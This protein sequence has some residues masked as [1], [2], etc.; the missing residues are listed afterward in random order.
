MRINFLLLVTVTIFASQPAA[1]TKDLLTDEARW[2]WAL[3]LDK[4]SDFRNYIRLHPNGKFVQEAR[5]KLLSK[6]IE[7]KAR[8]LTDTPQC[9]SVLNERAQKVLDGSVRK[10]DKFSYDLKLPENHFVHAPT[11][12]LTPR[13]QTSESVPVESRIEI[14]LVAL[15]RKRCMLIER[16]ANH[17]SGLSDACQ[18]V[19]ADPKYQFPPP[20]TVLAALSEYTRM[21]ATA[22]VC[23]VFGVNHHAL[24][25]TY[26]K[27]KI[28][29]SNERIEKARARVAAGK[30]LFPSEKGE[31]EDLEEGLSI[32]DQPV[33]LQTEQDAVQTRLRAMAGDAR[34][35]YCRKIHPEETMQRLGL[36][37]GLEKA[38][39]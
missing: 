33:L 14:T 13:G 9:R 16:W 6:E 26:R 15:R 17:G 1:Q 7:P 22:D 20:P 27:Q 5:A 12:V 24:A 39:P 21:V 32:L 2:K 38:R 19:P 25:E 11:Y 18:C 30:F 31:L 29:L 37:Y 34:E 4:P 8:L 36:Q 28:E 10:E 23:R 3:D 35:T